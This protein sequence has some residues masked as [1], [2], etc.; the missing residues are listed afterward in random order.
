MDECKPLVLGLWRGNGVMMARVIPY[1]GIMFLAF[2]KY[3]VA[4]QSAVAS[5]F[6]PGRG[7]AEDAGWVR[8]AVRLAAGSGAG[9]TAT[10]LTYPLDLL[11]ARYAAAGMAGIGAAAGL[12]AGTAAAGAGAAAAAG[13]VAG[14]AG[15]AGPSA[16]R[17]GVGL[18]AAGGAGAAAGTTGAAGAAVAVARA[19]GAVA[20]T[21]GAAGGARG[22]QGQYKAAVLTDLLKILQKDGP[23]GLYG[24]I[25]PTLIG[26]IPY[27]GISFATFESLKGRALHSLTSE[28]NLGPS[29]HI[30]HVR[31][32]LEHL[33]VT[34]TA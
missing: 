6:G 19:A 30:A 21:A 7:G 14:E 1:A 8:I 16:V 32:Q 17:L 18:A 12:A 31:A 2:P 20:G 15:V 5:M 10:A 24:G 23:R 22:V 26:I 4:V 27:A 9:A 3:E 11:R 28:L 25:T 13:V 33:R 34:S 29:G